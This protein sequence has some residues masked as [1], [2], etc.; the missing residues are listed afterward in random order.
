MTPFRQHNISGTTAQ[1]VEQMKRY[2]QQLVREL[3]LMLEQMEDN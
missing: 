3:N 2:L 1:Q